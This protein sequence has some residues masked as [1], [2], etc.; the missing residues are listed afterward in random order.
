MRGWETS[1]LEKLISW[2]EDNPELLRGSTNRWA[3]KVKKSVFVTVD[4]IDLKKIKAKYHNMKAAW[5]VAKQ[6]QDQS[7]F[8]LKE[9]D[10]ESSVNGKILLTK[11]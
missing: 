6:L 7:G 1:E 3:T 8:G 10:C 4:H 11:L 5:K 9:D 2:M